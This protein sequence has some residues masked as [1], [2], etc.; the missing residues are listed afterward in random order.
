MLHKVRIIKLYQNLFCL[1]SNTNEHLF[2]FSKLY[3]SPNFSS[4]RKESIYN[5]GSA[6]TKLLYTLHWVLLDA[7]DE[8]YL[9]EKERGVTDFNDFNLPLSS[10]TV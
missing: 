8:C 3:E 6:E 7:M 2:K 9:E 4:F 10:I 1:H 5:L